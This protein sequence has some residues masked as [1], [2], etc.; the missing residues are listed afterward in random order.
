[1]A[2]KSHVQA[3]ARV[4]AA[5]D[6]QDRRWEIPE[7]AA[8]AE[9]PPSP[10]PSNGTVAA[11]PPPQAPSPGPSFV[12]VTHDL[13]LAPAAPREAACRC[14]AV[15]YGPLSDPRFAW[16]VDRPA[17]SAG[18]L[19]LAISAEG[20]VC[21]VTGFDPVRASIAGVERQGSDVVV[22]VESVDQGRPVMRGA[23][24]VP[25]AP[26]GALVVRSLRAAPYGAPAAGGPGPCRLTIPQ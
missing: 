9:M 2:C 3:D 20:V 6:D 22:T 21:D 10:A 7:P 25:P 12:G 1:M 26:G 18:S 11:L 8:P 15:A 24:I 16:A 19:A 17:D 13:S 4:A 23:L 5:T 14:L